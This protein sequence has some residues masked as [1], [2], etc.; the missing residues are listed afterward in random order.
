MHKKIFLFFA[1]LAMFAVL[2]IS[3]KK[4]STS[5]NDEVSI[6]VHSMSFA[7]TTYSGT[8]TRVCHIVFLVTD[9]K[10]NPLS[11]Q[12][13]D[14][15]IIEGEGVLL[16]NTGLTDGS[17]YIKNTVYKKTAAN[18]TKLEA[19]VFGYKVSVTQTM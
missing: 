10:G 6:I 17:G 5:A 7:D 2:Y 3:C 15:Q 13:V 11:S 4:N 14:F 9:N 18:V 16:V 1:F 8:A 19:T 12:R